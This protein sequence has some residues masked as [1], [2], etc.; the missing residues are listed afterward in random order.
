MAKKT[1]RIAEAWRSARA[2]GAALRGRMATRLETR[3]RHRALKLLGVV[4][5]TLLAI[6][7]LELLAGFDM[8]RTGWQAIAGGDFFGPVF[9]PDEG[10]APQWKDRVQAVV[11][12]LGLPVLYLLWHWRDSNVRAQIDNQRKDINLKE[13]Q[14][15]QLRASGALPET[16]SAEAREQLQIASL[17][18]LR[19]FLRGEYG[20]S[21]RRPAFELLVAGHAAAMER[22]GHLQAMNAFR[23]TKPKV[24]GVGREIGFKLPMFEAKLSAVDRERLNIL[25]DEAA[26]IFGA[27]LREAASLAYPVAEGEEFDFGSLPLGERR[28]FLGK[29]RVENPGPGFP[30]NARRFDW[31]DL[32]RQTFTAS[33]SLARCS[34]VGADLWRAHLEGADLRADLRRAHLEG[35]HLWQ[36]H[37]EDADLGEA[38]LEDADLGE[39]HLEGADLRADLR[40]AHLEGA[41]LRRAHLEGADLRQAHLEGAYLARAHLEDAD[42]GEAHLEGADLRQAHLEGAY[43]WRAHLEGARFDARTRLAENWDERSEAERNAERR[44]WYERGAIFV[45]DDDK[46]TDLPPDDDSAAPADEPG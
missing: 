2:R 28:A 26:S 39:A 27:D 37:L 7:A 18:Q 23:A 34:F 29:F 24:N 19:G 38:H 36:A 16:L 25:R 32:S 15:V 11:L 10:D 30:L 14:E 1:G 31:I 9:F 4:L 21:F 3:R 41:D 42:L 46:P 8:V 5:A 17:H 44:K 35:A 45:D 20:E 12:L 6:R 33:R 13:F 22:I 43:L 40:R